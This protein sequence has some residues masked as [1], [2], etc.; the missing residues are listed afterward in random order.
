[1]S[2]NAMP[3]LVATNRALRT[4]LR[5]GVAV[6]YPPDMQDAARVTPLANRAALVQCTHG[7]G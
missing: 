4:M 1:M 3:S 7:A 5:D 6:E 2:S